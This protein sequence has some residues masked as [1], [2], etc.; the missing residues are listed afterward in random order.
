MKVFM[1]FINSIYWLWA[2]CVPVIICGIP[3]WLL[4]E[5]GSK[6]LLYTILFLIAGIIGGIFFAERIPKR[7][8]LSSFFSRISETPDIKDNSEK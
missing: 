2:F 1:F 7:E 3:G 6:N 4:Y 8:G 5:K